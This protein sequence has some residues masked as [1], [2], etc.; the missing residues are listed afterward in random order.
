VV[1][2]SILRYLVVAALLLPITICVI[3]GIGRLLVVMSDEAG[4]AV[5]DRVALGCGILWILDL[6]FL[7][8]A[9]G[10]NSLKPPGGPG[11]D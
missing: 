5:L 11:E 9:V 2:Q 8:V 7:S 6:V 10:I 4:G 3:L 1:P